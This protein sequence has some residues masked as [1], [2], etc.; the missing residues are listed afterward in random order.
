MKKYWIWMSAM[1]SVC[2]GLIVGCGKADAPADAEGEAAVDS[3]A[4][5]APA[6]AKAL[7]PKEEAKA[8]VDTAIAALRA[9][10]LD[11]VY[12]MLPESY[13]NDISGVVRAYAAKID[14][15][16]Y[17]Q[18]AKLLAAAGDLIAAQAQNL[19]EM[20][21]NPAELGLELDLPDAVDADAVTADQIRQAGEWIASVANSLSYDDF[22]AGNIRPLLSNPLTAGLLSEGIAQLPSDAIACAFADDTAAAQPD[23]IVPLRLTTRASDEDEPDTEDVQFVKVEGK[24]VPL[25][26]SQGWADTVCTAMDAAKAFEIDAD[27]RRMADTLA[28]VLTRT[29]E[30]L[31]SAQS[32]QELQ[33]QAMGAV[34]TIGM[35]MQQ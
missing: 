5:V 6:P 27:A 34:M 21:G 28:P 30:S 25:E 9:G 23:G 16:L 11:D 19:E 7:S 35:M 12:G 18:G 17:E 22:A 32:A 13:Q 10:R 20:L 31:K 3:A 24:W 26:M 14:R 2:A 15:P 1:V 8:S 4:A 33:A 29:L